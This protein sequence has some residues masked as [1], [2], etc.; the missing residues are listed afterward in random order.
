MPH[1]VH[2]IPYTLWGGLNLLCL[3]KTCGKVVSRKQNG[4]QPEE[5]QVLFKLVYPLLA[6]HDVDHGHHNWSHPTSKR[7][8]LATPL[9]FFYT[10]FNP[11]DVRAPLMSKYI[12]P[13]NGLNRADVAMRPLACYPTS[14]HRFN[15]LM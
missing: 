14:S 3:Y 7:N 13:I 11:L 8:F 15:R 10:A 4:E 12:C 1:K 2:H 9:V 5:N 6:F